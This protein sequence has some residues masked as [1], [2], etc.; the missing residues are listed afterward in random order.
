MERN[1]KIAVAGIL[2]ETNTFAPGVTILEHFKGEWV[3]GAEA[4]ASRYGG[5]RTSMGGVLSKA[6]AL[7][8]EL[9]PGLY[10]AATPSGMVEQETADALMNAVLGSIE[11]DIDGLVIIMH[12]AMAAEG[13][14]DMEGELLRRL[15]EQRGHDLPIAM[16]L[17][18]HANISPLMV[19]L[20]DFIVGYDTYPHIDMFERAEEAL[21]LLV[22]LAEGR[23]KPAMSLSRPRMLVVPQGMLTAEGAMKE[24][25]DEAFAMEQLPG[26]L[27]VTVA[28]G[29]PYS[30]VPDA[31]M[32]FVVTTDGDQALADQLA[33]RL[34]RL[35]WRERE[36]FKVSF[37][38]PAEA[39]RQAFLLPRGPVIVTEGSDNVGGGAPADATHL[40]TLLQ[41]PP[42][43]TL[44]VIR[45][46]EAALAAHAIGTGGEFEGAIGGKSD[47][48]HGKPVSIKGR[49]RLLFDGVYHHVGPYM[50]GQ[51][52]DM[53][54]TAVIE[55]GL[56]TVILTEK[57]TAPWDPGHVRSVGLW[58]EDF[59]LI[60]VKSAIAW[61]AAFGSVA[62]SI[63]HAD[64]PGCCTANLEHLDYKLLKRPIDPLDAIEGADKLS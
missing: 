26:V 55:C 36:R 32:S 16:T 38:A 64:T 45:D 48:L 30:D 19:E 51:R 42:V 23:H 49:I 13:Y 1:V 35:A 28:G 6:E 53:G 29:F 59:H 63:I 22:G 57:R 20:A 52:A 21:E 3:S 25:M 37:V 15:R 61:Q 46:V 34:S 4:F 14:P 60:V 50:T 43:K 40:L 5:T 18:L 44:V 41:S 17:D 7:G 8:I 47:D 39:V 11:S 12:G 10:A 62:K 56:L 9:I 54:K 31:G 24:L 33:D 27:N 2:H 58:A